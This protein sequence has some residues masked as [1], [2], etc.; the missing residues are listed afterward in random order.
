MALLYLV[1]MFQLSWWITRWLLLFL[2]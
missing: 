2:E 1:K